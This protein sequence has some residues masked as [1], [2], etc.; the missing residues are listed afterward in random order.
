MVEMNK[1]ARSVIKLIFRRGALTRSEIM[2]ALKMRLNAI[3]E[4]CNDLEAQNLIV[5][6]EPDRR[7]NCKL[8][9]N[10]RCFLFIGLEHHLTGANFVAADV[11]GGKLSSQSVALPQENR[12]EHLLTATEKFILPFRSDCIR[13]LGVS[14]IGLID[15]LKEIGIYSAHLPGWRDIPLGK[16]FRERFPYDFFLIDRVDADCFAAHSRNGGDSHI[17]VNIM[18]DGIGMS[19]RDPYNFWQRHMPMAGGI[20]HLVAVPNGEL[21]RC[22]NRGCLETVAGVG[23]VLERLLKLTGKCL[24]EAEALKLAASGDRLCETVLREA[25]EQMGSILAKVVGILGIGGITMR[26]TLCAEDGAYFAGA[27]TALFRE[28]I[29]PM[30]RMLVIDSEPRSADNSALGAALFARNEYI[31]RL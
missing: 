4:V 30:N 14:D 18:P 21:C 5:R 3:V 26:G 9:L 12:L 20:G 28:V 6:E 23:A 27:R 13:A 25:G 8:K 10:P 16:A 24:T 19:L 31:D 22:G 2:R 17:Y 11:L 15:P 1:Y 29:Y 7:R